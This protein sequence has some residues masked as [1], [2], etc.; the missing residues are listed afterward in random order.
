MLLAN[1]VRRISH[2]NIAKC[3]IQSNCTVSKRCIAIAGRSPAKLVELPNLTSTTVFTSFQQRGNGHDRRY[4]SSHRND[5]DDDA[6]DD[7]DNW[8]RQLPPFDDGYLS[9]PSVYLMLKN[10]L[11]ALLI[12]SYFDENF[13][14]KEFLDGA[15]QAMEVTTSCANLISI[16]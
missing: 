13:N 8:H 7:L 11:S 16:H 5:K 2:S 1:C 9:K 15:R 6:D 12:R 14:R 10:A 4:Y 3:L